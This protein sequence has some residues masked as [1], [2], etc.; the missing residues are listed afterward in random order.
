M[1]KDMSV[2]GIEDGARLARWISDANFMTSK[3]S[4]LLL[5]SAASWPIPTLIPAF[6]ISGSRATPLPSAK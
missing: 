6:S 1:T 3:R 2:P 4:R 5:H